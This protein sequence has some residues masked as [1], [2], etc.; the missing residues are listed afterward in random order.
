MLLAAIVRA[1]HVA[2]IARFSE[3]YEAD[4]SRLTFVQLFSAMLIFTVISYFKGH[5]VVS[6]A[7][8]LD[9]RSWIIIFYL[10]IICTVFAFFVQMEA[11]R[12]TSPARVSLLLG[13][14]PLWAA[15]VGVII[16][17]AQVTI[18]GLCGAILILVGTNWG[19]LAERKILNLG[20]VG[21]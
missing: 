19:R 21:D 20:E 5:N 13:T 11:V 17:G 3:R 18:L 1:I 2:I 10:A 14:E 4:S 9:E 15:L 8:H 16:G 6:L 7:T 12:R